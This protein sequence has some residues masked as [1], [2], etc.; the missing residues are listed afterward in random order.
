MNEQLK[1][2]ISEQFI[3]NSSL[4]E[5]ENN[6]IFKLQSV[7][8]SPSLIYRDDTLKIHCGPIIQNLGIRMPGHAKL[9]TKRLSGSIR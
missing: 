5:E 7:T 4:W 8:S 3:V 6:S 1:E 9:Q 2:E